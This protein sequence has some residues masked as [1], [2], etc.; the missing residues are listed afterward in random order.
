MQER[1]ITINTKT[2]KPVNEEEDEEGDHQEGEY[3]FDERQAVALP[4]GSKEQV[5]LDERVCL[6]G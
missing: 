1:T 2:S 6:C 5:R 3:Y 4:S